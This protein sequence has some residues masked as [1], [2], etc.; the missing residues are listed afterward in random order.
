[1]FLYW[2]KIPDVYSDVVTKQSPVQKLYT[3]RLDRFGLHFAY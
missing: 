3:I 2:S 1:M